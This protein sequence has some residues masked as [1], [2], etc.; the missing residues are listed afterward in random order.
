MTSTTSLRRYSRRP[1]ATRPASARSP[2]T[3]TC[4]IIRRLPCSAGGREGAEGGP[5]STRRAFERKHDIDYLCG[6]IEDAGL[7][8]SP[9]LSAASALTPWAVEFR[10]ADPFT[11]APPLDRAKALKIV[12]AIREWA[13][14][15][16]DSL[17]GGSA[18]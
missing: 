10:Y 11:D 14:Q 1:L 13:T 7:D 2:R 15:A 16:I 6:L 4:P 9:D 3:T 18:K 8:L 17:A 12:V 5:R